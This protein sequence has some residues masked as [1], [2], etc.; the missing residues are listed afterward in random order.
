[1]ESPKN[2]LVSTPNTLP[3]PQQPDRSKYTFEQNC[4][5]FHPHIGAWETLALPLQTP[6]KP[7]RILELGSFEGASTTW[8]LDNLANHPSS[9]MICID[10]FDGSMEHEASELQSLESR[11]YANVDKCTNRDKLRVIKAKTQDGLI[12][13]HSEGKG[14]DFIYVDAS[15][16]AIDVLADALLCWHMLQEGGTLVFDDWIWKRYNEYVYNPRIGIAAFLRC[17]EHVIEAQETEGQIWVSKVKVKAGPTWNSDPEFFY[18]DE[19]ALGELEVA[20][21]SRARFGG[22][23]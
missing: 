4:R 7:F 8:M 2:G 17:A 20:I 13:L 10:T 14:F 19:E 9:T 18:K 15:H 23:E 3:A 1:M 22:A 21:L 16:V 12:T 11:F 6:P 5:W